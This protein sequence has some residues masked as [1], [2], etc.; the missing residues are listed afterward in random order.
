MR[1]M[2]MPV[3]NTTMIDNGVAYATIVRNL[4]IAM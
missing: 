4:I 2:K 1:K 3:T